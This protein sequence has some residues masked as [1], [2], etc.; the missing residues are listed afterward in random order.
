MMMM[1]MIIMRIMMIRGNLLLQMVFM[2]IYVGYHITYCAM[3]DDEV[4]IVC[5]V[6][7]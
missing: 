3:C 6:V 5:F 4:S 1:I 2:T 7:N